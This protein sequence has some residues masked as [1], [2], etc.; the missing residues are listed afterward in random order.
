MRE[1][2]FLVGEHIVPVREELLL[3]GEHIVP[4]REEVVLVGEHIVLVREEVLIVRNENPAP[5]HP[6]N[7]RKTPG[8]ALRHPVLSTRA[9][10]EGAGGHGSNAHGD[11]GGGARVTIEG[12]AK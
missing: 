7:A 9:A 10:G 12:I 5:D 4:V 2:F 11:G 1:D 8:L 3:V 6:G